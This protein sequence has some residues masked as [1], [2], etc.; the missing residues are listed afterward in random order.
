MRPLPVKMRQYLVSGDDIIS[1]FVLVRT[2]SL[3][4][5]SGNWEDA[6]WYTWILAKHIPVKFRR[7][8]TEIVHGCTGTLS[9]S[10]VPV[11]AVLVAKM[12]CSCAVNMYSIWI[13]PRIG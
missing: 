6:A 9:V 13:H 4:M 1:Q 3:S 7:A 11:M 5:P 2:H 8:E 10:F 12:F